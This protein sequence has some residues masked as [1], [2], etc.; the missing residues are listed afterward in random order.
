MD[1]NVEHA[2]RR[3]GERQSATKKVADAQAMVSELRQSQRE[4]EPNTTSAHADHPILTT[5]ATQALRN[6]C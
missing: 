2:K 6:P 3:S 4:H 1:E 5:T